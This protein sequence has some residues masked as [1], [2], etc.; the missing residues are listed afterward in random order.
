[1]DDKKEGQYSDSNTPEMESWMELSG[2]SNMI[3]QF[4]GRHSVADVS[5]E[6]LYKYLMNPQAHIKQIRNA[7]TYLTNRHGIL[8]DVLR[9][10]QSLPTLKY[11]LIWSSYEDMERNKKDEKKVQRF[12]DDIDII[13]FLRKGLYEV[14]EQGT[15]VTCLRSKKY[16]QFLNLDEIVIRKQRNGKWVVEV[17]LQAVDSISNMQSKLEKIDSLPDEVTIKRYNAYR[18]SNDREKKRYVE[19]SNCHVISIG[20]K[21]NQPFGLPLTLGSWLSILQK[22][23]IN[24]VERSVSSR[25]LSQIITLSADFMDKDKTKPVPKPLLE[26]YFNEVSKLINKKDDMKSQKS[27]S[28][29]GVVALPHFLSLDSVKMDTTLFKEELYEKLDNDIFMSLGISPALSYGGGGNYASANVNS[30]KFFSYIT[31]ILEQ[32]ESVI[33]DY[34]KMILPEDQRC[35]I[36]FDRSTILDKEAKIEQHKELFMQTNILQPYIESLFGGGTFEAIMNQAKYEQSLN[37]EK[38]IRPAQNAHTS[39]GKDSDQDSQPN[40]ENTEKERDNDNNGTPS[41]ADK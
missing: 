21:K 41:P 34:I 23:I 18:N 37:K 17:D 29:G 11:N 25:M 35:K 28:G 13:D 7:S 22:E 5:I 15:I 32:F 14:A 8:K 12:L 31:V 2:L 38:Y 40:N 3:T 16:V 36:I 6:D 9:M 20:A 24:K 30:E 1:M 26:S 33:N 27:E 19:I 39:S 4:G 10:V